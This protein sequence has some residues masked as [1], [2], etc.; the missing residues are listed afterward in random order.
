MGFGNKYVSVDMALRE[1]L[2]VQV[3]ISVQCCTGVVMYQCAI[4]MS[5]QLLFLY[6][7]ALKY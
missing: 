7:P 3:V 4:G 5:G 2:N 6:D 1:G